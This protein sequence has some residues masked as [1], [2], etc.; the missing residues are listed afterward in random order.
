MKDKT[1]Q[2]LNWLIVVWSL[3]LIATAG[4]IIFTAC[5]PL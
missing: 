5:T 1:L 2:L 4:Y 3:V